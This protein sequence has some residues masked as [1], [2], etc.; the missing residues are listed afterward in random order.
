MGGRCSGVV[1]GCH[2]RRA[3]GIVDERAL[4]FVGNDAEFVAAHVQ[5]R[6]DSGIDADAIGRGDEFAVGDQ[7]ELMGAGNDPLRIG[8]GDIPAQPQNARA[9]V[10]GVVDLAG[11]VFR[12]ELDGMRAFTEFRGPVA[13]AH[14]QAPVVGGADGVEQ[15]EVRAGVGVE[16]DVAAAVVAAGDEVVTPM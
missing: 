16:V 11:G 8:G 6:V 7:A 14:Q 15:I 12:A 5:Q 1:V 2:G 9:Q 4:Q 13:V 3:V 10:R